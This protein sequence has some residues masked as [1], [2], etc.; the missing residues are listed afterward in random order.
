MPFL[1]VVNSPFLVKRYHEDNVFRSFRS[2]LVK[3][4][5]FLAGG[6]VVNTGEDMRVEE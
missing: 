5:G 2:L 6:L 3:W 1:I 4:G